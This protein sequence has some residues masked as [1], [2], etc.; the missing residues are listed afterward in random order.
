MKSIINLI[1]FLGIIICLIMYINNVSVK[2]KEETETF[3][4]KETLSKENIK[5]PEGNPTISFDYDS[6]PEID[7]I[8]I[9]VQDRFLK[10][11]ESGATVYP[12]YTNDKFTDQKMIHDSRMYESPLLKNRFLEPQ[13]AQDDLPKT[14]KQLFDE[15]ITDFKNLAPKKDGKTGD[16]ISQGAFNLNLYAPDSFSYDNEKPENGGLNKETNLYAFDPLI[17]LDRAVF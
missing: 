1:I 2:Q 17:D 16:F 3:T 5:D 4:T 12:Q 9:N 6:V 10:E 14:L 15:S 7:N 8:N 11:L 13:M